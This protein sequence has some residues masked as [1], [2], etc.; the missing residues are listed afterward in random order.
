MSSIGMQQAIEDKVVHCFICAQTGW[1]QWRVNFADLV[2]EEVEQDVSHP[3]LHKYTGLGPGQFVCCLK[4]SMGGQ[5]IVN[6]C[7][8]PSL[9]RPSPYSSPMDSKLVLEC[10]TCCCKA[11]WQL[12]ILKDEWECH[13]RARTFRDSCPGLHV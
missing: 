1:A 13:I 12:S 3:Q 4:I 9:R 5:L 11:A 8:P 2:Q 10:C 7:Q 6:L